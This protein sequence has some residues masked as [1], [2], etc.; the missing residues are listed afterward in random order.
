MSATEFSEFVN[1]LLKL[2]PSE[3]EQVFFYLQDQFR[4]IRGNGI[5]YEALSWRCKQAYMIIQHRTKSQK[6][7]NA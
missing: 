5:N 6:S 1:K 7:V 2:K 3:L 4:H